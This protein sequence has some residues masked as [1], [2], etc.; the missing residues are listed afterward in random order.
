MEFTTRILTT[1][2]RVVNLV[3]FTARIFRSRATERSDV[4]HNSREGKYISYWLL[5]LVRLLFMETESVKNGT[6][7]AFFSDFGVPPW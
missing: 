7:N 6:R 5:E 3:Q 1:R 4:G 2:V